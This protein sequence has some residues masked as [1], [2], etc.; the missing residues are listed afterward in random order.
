DDACLNSESGPACAL[1]A[2]QHSKMPVAL[3]KGSRS[4]RHRRHNDDVV[5][6]VSTAKSFAKSVASDRLGIFLQI[7]NPSLWPDMLGCLSSV[8][9]AYA[10]IG[11]HISFLEGSFPNATKRE[12]AN[13]VRALSMR[14]SLYTLTV[15]NL[16]ED[17]GQFLAQLEQAEGEGLQY[18]FIL[19][20]HTKTDT[21]WRSLG[22]QS[23]CGTKWQVRSAIQQFHEKPD[24]DLIGPVGLVYGATTPLSD[25]Y[26]SLWGVHILNIAEAARGQPFWGC[27]DDNVRYV[28]DQVCPD[29]LF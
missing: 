11:V 1:H 3:P 14:I 18:D 19:K 23:M 27:N 6:G 4:T 29:L 20:V 7:G 15:P 2:L 21:N 17:I 25:I 9:D 8:A 10:N 16:G 24:V 26:P 5:D 13:S 22:L 12:I 28:H